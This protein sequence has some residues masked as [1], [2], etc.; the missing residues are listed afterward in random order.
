[1]A[2]VIWSGGT[3]LVLAQSEADAK[4]AKKRSKTLAVL[5]LTAGTL[6]AVRSGTV[7]L[8][9][10]SGGLTASATVRLVA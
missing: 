4:A 5:D 6:T 2:S 3:G 8:T 7:T 9:V 10:A 1:P